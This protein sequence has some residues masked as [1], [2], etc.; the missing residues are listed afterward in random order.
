VRVE[1]LRAF[2]FLSIA[3]SISLL[4]LLVLPAMI[5][6]LVDESGLSE[7]FAGMSASANFAGGASIAM[8]MAFR[9]HHID[10]RRATG[11]AFAVAA[12][13][14]V[15]SAFSTGSEALF[16]SARFAAGIGTGAA[17]T[18]IASA[19]ARYANA[20]RGYG[21][22]VTLQFIISGLGL[23]VLP[24]HASALG[25]EGM[26]LG[27]AGLEI[28]ALLLL[29]HLPG[30]A[31]DLASPASGRSEHGVL[32][33]PATILAVLSFGVFEAANTAQFTYIE[34]LGV[35][36]PLTEHHIG[37][38]LLVASL[39]G[40]PGAFITVLLGQRFGR[41]SPLTFGI[42]LS[43]LGMLV[44]V[45]A[46]GLLA[47]AIAGSCIGFAWAF[48]LPFIQGLLASLDAHGSAVAAGASASTIGGAAGPA[49][50]ASIVGNGQY[51]AVLLAAI[52]LLAVACAG[53]IVSNTQMRH[54]A[55]EV[56]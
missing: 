55:L 12:A 7:A 34:R 36:I 2:W 23:Y 30:K 26:F 47:Y 31:I 18:C 37:I 56:R 28:L 54:T 33:A 44:L 48:C 53:F 5:G 35:S 1:N 9:M 40:I 8:L 25:T 29:R 45:S 49:V 46:D 22:F 32:L 27:I 21:V 6:V 39:A 14:D 4:P 11:V 24:V 52:G 42:A 51:H 16:L 41:V 3:G 38:A 10:L 20:D 43:V 17:Y 13:M 15:V 50:A 19:F